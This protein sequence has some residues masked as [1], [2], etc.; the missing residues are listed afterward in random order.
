MIITAPDSAIYFVFRP[1]Q[2]V[3]I[4]IALQTT[5]Q[6]VKEPASPS[7][8]S[9]IRNMVY[10]SPT[11]NL[12][13]SPKP[14]GHIPECTCGKTPLGPSQKF[15]NPL[16]SGCPPLP[17]SCPHLSETRKAENKGLVIRFQDP[18]SRGR[19]DQTHTSPSVNPATSP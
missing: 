1:L 8:H 10:C 13:M 7:A 14:L 6:L 11:R 15:H 17:C 12:G 5:M 18:K 19:K 16:I 9:F 4:P 2:S 3:F